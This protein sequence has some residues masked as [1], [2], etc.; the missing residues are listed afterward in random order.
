MIN[1]RT[2]KQLRYDIKKVQDEYPDLAVKYVNDL[3]SELYGKI[4]I[5]DNLGVLQEEFDIRV[6]IPLFYPFGFPSLIEVANR[7]ERI[8][9]R[10]INEAGYCCVE[11]T[12]KILLLQKRGITL[13]EFFKNYVYKFFCWQLLYETIGPTQLRQWEHGKKGIKQFYFELLNSNNNN[14]VR[15]L[16]LAVLNNKIPNRKAL[17]PCGSSKIIKECHYNEFNDLE[18]IGREQLQKDI[19]IF[20]D[21]DSN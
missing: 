19:I 21:K 11:I 18:R 5:F 3:P 13:Q 7:I 16:I 17:C 6:L 14:T 4:K 8:L 12:Q 10:H 20:F 15:K 9:D 1:K 2:L